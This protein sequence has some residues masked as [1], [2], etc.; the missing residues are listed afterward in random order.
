MPGTRRIRK[1]F[2]AGSFVTRSSMAGA[3]GT[4]Q[5]GQASETGRAFQALAPAQPRRLQKVILRLT[6][7][8]LELDIEHYLS[9]R[10]LTRRWR[11]GL[12]LTIPPG[13]VPIY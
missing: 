7:P 10:I 3:N 4:A 9:L 1:R 12:V 13:S 8:C 5:P 6:F 11:K 2:S